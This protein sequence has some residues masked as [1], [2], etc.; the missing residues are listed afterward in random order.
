MGENEELI[1]NYD[2]V[3]MLT[4]DFYFDENYDQSKLIQ[5]EKKIKNEFKKISKH[6]FLGQGIESVNEIKVYFLDDEDKPEYRFFVHGSNNDL[7]LKIVRQAL[8]EFINENHYAFHKYH[9]QLNFEIPSMV[10]RA[11]NKFNENMW[12]WCSNITEVMTLSGYKGYI[13]NL[14]QF[15]KLYLEKECSFN[16]EIHPFIN[17][18]EIEWRIKLNNFGNQKICYNELYRRAAARDFFLYNYQEDMN[19]LSAMKYE[20]NINKGSFLALELH[21]NDSFEDLDKNFIISIKFLNPVK[22]SSENYKKIRKLLEITKDDYSLLLNENSE[23]FAIGRLKKDAKVDY[24]KVCF[25]NFLEWR[26]YKNDIEYLRF[27][28]MIPQLPEA[29]TGIQSKDI[30]LLVRTFEK[31]DVECL[32]MII[33]CATE[34]CHGT[35]VVFTEN[36]EEEADRLKESGICI[37][38]AKLTEEVARYATSIDGALLCDEKGNCH[39]IGII[40]DG[41]ASPKADLSR[42]SRYNSAIRYIEQQK[43]KNKKTFIVIVSEDKYIDC[44]STSDQLD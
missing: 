6:D 36:A 22:L 35:M 40:L 43:S 23:V 8:E 13:F 5:I 34:Q 10:G 27:E 18:L 21:K 28:N 20:N 31:I 16:G 42:G 4:N 11:L 39:A 25:T 7:I 29:S 19:A 2:A 3:E 33:D 44:K 1:D 24:Y 9:E 37:R 14:I 41:K 38:S 15:N 12:F 26:F 17:E 32:K 30:N